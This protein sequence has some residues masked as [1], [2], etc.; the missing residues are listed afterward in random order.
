VFRKTEIES[1]R[2]KSNTRATIMVGLGSSL[3][4]RGKRNPRGHFVGGNHSPDCRGRCGPDVGE[5]LFVA[6]F[7]FLSTRLPTE[8]DNPR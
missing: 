6:E 2:E 8:C 5:A 7:G 3:N 1:E 4:R